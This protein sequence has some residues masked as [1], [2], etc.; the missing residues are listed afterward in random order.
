M[1]AATR[2]V[3]IQPT[4]QE[5][6]FPSKPSPRDAAR[7]TSDERLRAWYVETLELA[8]AKGV[9]S[10]SVSLS[11][12]YF[13]QENWTLDALPIFPDGDDLLV[14]ADAPVGRRFPP[15]PVY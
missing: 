2:P 1:P 14:S 10:D 15:T 12:D 11:G 5:F 6:I 3:K 13:R 4:D 7:S 9:L 8:V